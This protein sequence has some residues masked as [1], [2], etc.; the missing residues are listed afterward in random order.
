M[1]I[2]I[3]TANQ[4]LCL[5]FGHCEVF[6]FLEIDETTNT[7]I[8]TEE[9]TPPPHQPGII[10]PWVKE[11][12]ASIVIAGGM[13]GRA[14]QIFE[15]FGIKLITGA[16]AEAPEKVALDYLNGTLITGI[17]TCDHSNCGN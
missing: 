3:P 6:T 17:N 16:P 1:K 14:Q 4:K 13:G 7:I 2:A 10:P 9:I 12:G 5:H 15:H 11:Q 8:S